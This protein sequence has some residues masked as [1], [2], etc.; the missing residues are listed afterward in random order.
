MSSAIRIVSPRRDGILEWE[1]GPYIPA[2]PVKDLSTRLIADEARPD[3]VV[4]SA[5]DRGSGQFKGNV[6]RS[7]RTL[8]E[9]HFGGAESVDE[10]MNPSPV[11]G[12]VAESTDGPMTPPPHLQLERNQLDV[13][14][15]STDGKVTPTRAELMETA[16]ITTSFREAPPFSGELDTVE[17]HLQQT[18]ESSV[19][20]RLQ[21]TTGNSANERQQQTTGSSDRRQLQPT[22]DSSETAT[23]CCTGRARIDPGN[24]IPKFQAR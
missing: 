22:M 11:L 7:A 12:V 17:G 8:G 23:H 21:Q 9:V 3:K 4:N 2:S 10:R 13:S 18:T 1:L 16:E 20:E 19:E 24:G 14:P 6:A 15:E 5:Q